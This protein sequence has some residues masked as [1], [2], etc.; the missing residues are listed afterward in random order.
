MKLE[1]YFQFTCKL[2]CRIS[3]SLIYMNCIIRSMISLK[4]IRKSDTVDNLFATG[5]YAA[6]KAINR[7][8]EGKHICNCIS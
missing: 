3:H 8:S 1:F 2:F 6:S 7:T 4:Y 5:T